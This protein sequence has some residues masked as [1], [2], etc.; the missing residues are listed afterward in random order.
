M[1]KTGPFSLIS[2]YQL[3]VKIL[4][5]KDVVLKKMYFCRF[6]VEIVNFN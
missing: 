2:K 5:L 6:L 3:I 1:L 4:I